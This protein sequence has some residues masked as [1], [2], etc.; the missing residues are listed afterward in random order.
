M[1]GCGGGGAPRNP[2]AWI[3]VPQVFV[4]H[5]LPQD[6][7]AVGRLENRSRVT[8]RVRAVDVRVRDA[9]GRVLA[10]TAG[11]TS[12][13]AHGLFGAFQQPSSLP[14]R[15]L[16]RLGRIVILDPGASSPLF[17]SWRLP[18]GARQPIRIDYGSGVLTVPLATRAAAL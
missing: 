17:A 1:S 12:S 13:Y 11:F 4:P 5:D 14:I 2:L 3:G 18:A 7:I 10:S 16:V 9:Q 8:V 6:R 15:E